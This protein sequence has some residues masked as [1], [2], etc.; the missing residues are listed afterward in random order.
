MSVRVVEFVD[1]EGK[2]G[3]SRKSV[4]DL[5]AAELGKAYV[6]SVTRDGCPACLRLKPKLERLAGEMRE[7]HSDR[8]AFVR[9]HVKYADGDIVESL[10]SKDVFGHYFYP[11]LFVLVRSRDRGVV[12]LFRWVSP[13]MSEVKRNVLNALEIAEALKKP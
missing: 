9:V 10:R 6:V 4:L 1:L 2:V 5:L 12:E 3:K 8:V 7:K 13:L 11:T